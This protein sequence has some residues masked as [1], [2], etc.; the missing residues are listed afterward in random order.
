MLRSRAFPVL[1]SRAFPILRPR[2]S[3]PLYKGPGRQILHRGPPLPVVSRLV[4]R[5]GPPLSA[6][7]RLVWHRGSLQPALFRPAPGTVPECPDKAGL[8]RR[9]P[10]GA[11]QRPPAS[12]TKI[13]KITSRIEKIGVNA[14][15][16]GQK[17]LFSENMSIFAV[18]NREVF[19][20]GKHLERCRSGRSGRT[21][22]AV[23]GQLYR[24]FESLSLRKAHKVAKNPVNHAFT[25]FFIFGKSAEKGI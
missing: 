12:S 25:G 8:P 7:S 2:D 23:Y 11:L 21:R 1:R 13:G 4:W 18:P 10:S 14:F 15:F 16:F 9:W 17:Y 24:G 3:S 5:R 19:G 6:V 22:N 20:C